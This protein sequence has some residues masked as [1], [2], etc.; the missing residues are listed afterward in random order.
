MARAPH[1]PVQPCD[2]LHVNL[3]AVAPSGEP[4]V[5]ENR[6]LQ[7]ADLFPEGGVAR[8][9]QAA[10]E[11]AAA[12]AVAVEVARRQALLAHGPA[13]ALQWPLNPKPV[14]CFARVTMSMEADIYPLNAEEKSD[15]ID[16]ALGKGPAFTRRSAT[17]LR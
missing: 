2:L 6:D 9:V 14:S 7:R 13:Q 10:G 5:P 8:V 4:D 17:A 15:R 1:Q 3:V 12:E 11:V 16:G